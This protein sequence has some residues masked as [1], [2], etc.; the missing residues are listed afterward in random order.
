MTALVMMMMGMVV[1]ENPPPP[2]PTITVHPYVCDWNWW[3]GKQAGWE[4]FN[5]HGAHES[6]DLRLCESHRLGVTHGMS[7]DRAGEGLYVTPTGSGVYEGARCAPGDRKPRAWSCT[8]GDR[9]SSQ[10]RW[11]PVEFTRSSGVM[12]WGCFSSDPKRCR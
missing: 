4:R 1:C 5:L 3:R 11:T 6:S 7:F 8:E 2:K 10:C 12:V 9:L